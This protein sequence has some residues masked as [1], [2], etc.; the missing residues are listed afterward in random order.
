M[1]GFSTELSGSVVFN[2]GSLTQAALV[3]SLNALA[4]TGSF[5]ITGS[6]LTFNGVDVMS[7]IEA[8][9]AGANIHFSKF[10]VY[11]LGMCSIL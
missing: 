1:A 7:K 4:L 2:S 5:N 10:C 8:L 6:E 9:E 11:R 3:P